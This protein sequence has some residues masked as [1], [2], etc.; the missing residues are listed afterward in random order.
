MLRHVTWPVA[1]FENSRWWKA[2]ILKMFFSVSAVNRP[3]LMKLVCRC[4]FWF[5]EWSRD[6]KYFP[7]RRWR[8]DAILKLFFSALTQRRIFRLTRNLEWRC[9][10]SCHVTWPNSKFRNVNA[11]APS[12]PRGTSKGSIVDTEGYASHYTHCISSLLDP[13]ACVCVCK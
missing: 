10:I 11:S 4:E 7:N 2:V 3:I 12:W 13:R 6:E 5:W 9:R 8:T 1:N